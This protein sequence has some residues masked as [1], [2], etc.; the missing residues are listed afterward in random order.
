MGWAHA[1]APGAHILLLEPRSSSLGDLMTAVDF[2]RQQSG[3]PVIWARVSPC[4]S[5]IGS[6]CWMPNCLHDTPAKH[7]ARVALSF[8]R[9]RIRAAPLSR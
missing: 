3:V 6:F 4:G 7:A 9:K 5:A 8:I 1:I 2:V